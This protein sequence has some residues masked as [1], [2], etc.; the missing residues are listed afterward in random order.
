MVAKVVGSFS[1]LALVIGV[2][3]V[4]LSFLLPVGVAMS[5]YVDPGSYQG[6]YFFVEDDFDLYVHTDF[7]NYSFSFYV[8]NYE[9]L[10]ASL[11]SGTVNGTHPLITVENVEEYRGVMHFPGPGTYGIVV[12][13]PYDKSIIIRF[14][15]L[16]YPRFSLLSTGIVISVPMAVIQLGMLLSNKGSAS[17]KRQSSN[18]AQ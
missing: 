7:G 13:H 12:T 6:E 3:L 17:G 18:S 1:R 2:T 4:V 14:S 5:E 11:D 15:A 16:A 8:L 9:D 10:L